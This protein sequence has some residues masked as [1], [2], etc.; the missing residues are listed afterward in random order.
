[1]LGVSMFLLSKWAM[2]L[3]NMMC[4]GSERYGSVVGRGWS[5]SL[6]EDR[7]D[8]S[9]FLVIWE[10]TTVKRKLVDLCYAWD[11]FLSAEYEEVVGTLSGPVALF[12]FIPRSLRTP[13][14]VTVMGLISAI[15]RFGSCGGFE[16]SSLVKTEVNWSLS[17]SA[18]C[19]LP[20][21]VIPSFFKGATPKFSF[22]LDLMYCQKTLWFSWSSLSIEATWWSCARLHV[23]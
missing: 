18:F 7:G 23:S 13:F 6:L 12:G 3:L 1:M 9:S 5:V 16:S 17:M 4:S 8:I 15:W 2:M 10:C 21:K 22:F 20:L 14:S 19:L 11:Q